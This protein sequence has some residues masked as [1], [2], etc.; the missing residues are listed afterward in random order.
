MGPP[1]KG[2]TSA[3]RVMT[4]SAATAS[5]GAGSASEPWVS[6][7]QAASHLGVKKISVYRWIE[8][9]GLPARK[10]GKLWKLKLSDVD[11]W[12]RHDGE[13]GEPKTR[14]ASAED[15]K[16]V[17]K[18]PPKR[19]RSASHRVLV[20]DDDELVRENIGDF[21]R[22]KGHVVQLAANGATAL[23]LL[24]APHRT[25]PDLIIL[26]LEMPRLDGWRFRERQLD[27]P[28]IAAIP[29][30]VVTATTSD[31]RLGFVHAVLRKPL[32]LPLLAEAMAEI[33]A[34]PRN[35]GA[36]T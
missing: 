12:V 14:D 27:A 21:L 10:I 23:Q 2:A 7:E 34:E 6:V 28:E 15:R 33:L 1:T 32:R 9:R 19:R 29:V 16:P 36:S 20:I 4:T 24:A 11:A 3:R 22:D 26:D 31:E 8:T 17:A 25:K 35:R 18:A 5:D 13:T 30:I